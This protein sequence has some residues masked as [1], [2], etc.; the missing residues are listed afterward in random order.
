MRNCRK[1]N[2]KTTDSSN[3]SDYLIPNFLIEPFSRVKEKCHSPTTIFPIA[4]LAFHDCVR[5]SRVERPRNVPPFDSLI[6]SV[7]KQKIFGTLT[8]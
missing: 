8:N 3:L 2:S 6:L 5:G 7:K 1:N 4:F